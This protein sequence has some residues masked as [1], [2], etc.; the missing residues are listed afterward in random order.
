LS[1]TYRECTVDKYPSGVSDYLIAVEV[2][3]ELPRIF[4]HDI[5]AALAI[6][7]RGQALMEVR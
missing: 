1:D 3:V 4:S 6:V 2:S 7:H 5:T